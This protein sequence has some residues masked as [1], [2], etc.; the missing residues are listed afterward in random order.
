MA[1]DEVD[2]PKTWKQLLRS[3][4]KQKWLKA[5]DEEYLSLLG[6]ETW[7][8]VPR[9][10]KRKIIKSKWVFK[11]KRHPDKS[12]KKLKARLVAMGY[13]QVHGVDYQ[14][15]FAPTLRLETLCL[16]LSLLAIRRWKGR[17]V[18]FKTAS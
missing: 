17:Q 9:P 2:T 6:M 7:K 13:T 10:L 3:P 15:V 14:E 1:D 18:D 5:A 16:I 4:H 8:L 11:I 12:I